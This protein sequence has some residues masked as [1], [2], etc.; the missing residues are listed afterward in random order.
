MKRS[1]FARM[2]SPL[3]A[4]FILAPSA[5]VYADEL[6][7]TGGVESPYLGPYGWTG[8]GSPGPP[9]AHDYIFYPYPTLDGWTYSY[10]HSGLIN[11]QAG[12]DTYGPSPRR[13]L[14]ETNS[15][16]CRTTGA[17]RNTL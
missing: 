12:S 1:I 11:A 2:A 10:N 13:D 17:S 5:Y 6:I 14:A 15:W 16:P 3:A 7:Q 4:I 8:P 9:G